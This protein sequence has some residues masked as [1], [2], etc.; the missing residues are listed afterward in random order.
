[1]G[2]IPN[3]AKKALDQAKASAYQLKITLMGLKPPIWRRVLVPGDISLSNLH[4]T[5]QFVMGWQDSHLHIFHVGKEHFGTKSQDLDK[6]QDERKVILQDIAPEAGAEFIYEM[7][8]GI[9]GRTRYGLRKLPR[10][11]LNFRE[12]NVWPGSGPARLRTAA[13]CEVTRTCLPPSAI[14]NTSSMTRW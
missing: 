4:Y 7:T 8:W 2:W 14:P 3:E 10:L 11:R 12:L 6:V 13:A 5:I 9:A 1:M